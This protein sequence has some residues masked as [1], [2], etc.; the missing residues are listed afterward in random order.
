M[1]NKGITYYW[2]DHNLL[3]TMGNRTRG[4]IKA[5]YLLELVRSEE[6]HV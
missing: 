2:G 5:L 1:V 4:R 3:I 6:H